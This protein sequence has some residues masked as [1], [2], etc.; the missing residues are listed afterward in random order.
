MAYPKTPIIEIPEDEEDVEFL[1]QLEAAEAHALSLSSSSKRRR[2][3]VE[4]GMK[5]ERERDDCVE[6]IQEG[7]YTAA[8]KG[9]KSLTWKKQQMAS[10]AVSVGPAVMGG[11]GGTG[12]CFKCGKE[13]HWARDCNQTTAFVRNVNV[14]PTM[15][16]PSTTVDG[17]VEKMCA[18]GL[19]NCL[20]LTANTERNRGRMFFRCPARQENGG[21]GF[22]EWYDSSSGNNSSN[23]GSRAWTNGGQQQLYQ[24]PTG[25]GSPAF[26]TSWNDSD[27]GVKS[28]STSYNAA[29]KF[30]LTAD[31]RTY[32]VGTGSSC[33][34]CGD[35]G[36]WAK[37]CPITSSNTTNNG[38]SACKTSWNDYD[39]RASPLSTSN[40]A[41]QKFDTTA[42]HNKSYGV[43]TVSS[44]FKCGEE[45]HWAK[46][47]RSTSNITNNGSLVF[48]NSWNDYDKGAS[49][50]TPNY[51][52]A[53]KS[54]ATAD[55]K[56]YGVKTGSSCFKCGEEGHWARACPMSTDTSNNASVKTSANA[57]YKCGLS[58]HWARD[59]SQG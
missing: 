47:C 29:Q 19:G 42:D 27:R 2:I 7:A 53:Q 38:S 43:R 34:K 6:E 26:K 37:D 58:G 32:G 50:L 1:S 13:G 44:C 14:G 21:C 25:Q 16:T 51:G 54:D 36:H 40:G 31:N 28:L 49:S 18:C 17:G 48:R 23:E 8:L 4:S 57:C 59:C 22:F 10:S 5:L 41:V 46:D 11:G 55:N 20:L 15:M 45:G 35:E 30:E 9:S 52:A 39:K 12:A 56:V 3:T 24:H 33:F